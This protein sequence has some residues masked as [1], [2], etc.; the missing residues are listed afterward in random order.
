M[1]EPVN[2]PRVAFGEVAATMRAAGV[3]RFAVEDVSTAERPSW[4]ISVTDGE[5]RSSREGIGEDLGLAA[6]RAIRNLEEMRR[7][8]P[9]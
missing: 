3:S 4:M 2:V 6:A 1:S 8:R 9:R 5:T 7:R